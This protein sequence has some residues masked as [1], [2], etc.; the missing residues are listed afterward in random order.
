V[1]AGQRTLD[2][3]L[4][5]AATAQPADLVDALESNDT[6]VAV[7][8]RFPGSIAAAAASMQ[9]A[10]QTGA[11]DEVAL[12]EGQRVVQALLP[13]LL[14]NAGPDLREQYMLLL[15]EQLSVARSAGASVCRSLLT[16]DAAVRRSLPPPL[17]L[18]ETDWLA[19]AAAEP[20]RAGA[21]R[22]ATALETEVIRRKL[23][24]RAPALLA[25]LWRPEGRG[26]GGRECEMQALVL[27]EAAR[28][29]PAER[30]LAARLVFE[31]P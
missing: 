4:P 3:E 24:D 5:P 30:R 2:V 13:R 8:H 15:A 12:V 11:A 26:L 16:G 14:F 29:P 9:A 7:E 1:S 27:A 6:W 21:P 28:L 10:R 22:A 20:Q 19:A 23:G 25:Q 17:V 31:R 18:R